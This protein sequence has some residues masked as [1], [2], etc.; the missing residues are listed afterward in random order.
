M[1]GRVLGIIL[2]AFVFIGCN[3]NEEVSGSITG[4]VKDEITGES[5]AGAEIAIAILSKSTQT[6]SDGTFSFTNIPVGTYNL[7]VAKEGYP[8]TKKVV[9]V[10]DGQSVETSITMS[11]TLPTVTPEEVTLNYNRLSDE[12]EIENPGDATLAI[13]ITSSQSWLSVDQVSLQLAPS[14]KKDLTI[15]ADITG[16]EY[17]DYE[18]EVTLSFDGYS[19][20]V[21]VTVY[22]VEQA[23]IIWRNWYLS[24]PIDN[25]DGKATSI[26]YEDIVNDNL[27]NEEREYFDYDETTGSYV[28]WTKFTGY[29]TS[30]EYGLNEGSYCRTELREFWQGNQ[31]V[32][33]NWYFNVGET[34][35]MESTLNVDFVEGSRG[36]TFVGQIH[37]KKSTI[38]GVDNGPA[39]VK[40]LWENGDIEVEYYV[41]PANPN[42]EWTSDDNDKSDRIT[43][44]NEKFTI[45]LKVEDGVLYWAL[46]CAAKGIDQDYVMLYDYAS[47]GYHY[48]NYFKTGN[49]FQWNVDYDK[50]A[51]VRLY[52]VLTHHE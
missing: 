47:N 5:I 14:E 44:D 20:A 21:P 50:E 15:T 2:I 4:V 32:N 30:G 1:L 52:K 45:K 49:Y 43:V 28:M 34:H 46:E 29:T 22:H 19:I 16:L 24:V 23:D 8:E 48:D 9:S 40:V 18:E 51:Q 10:L 26:Y 25:G 11:K 17:G 35:I 27:T 6:Q 33:D 39:T 36:R 42:G 41:A 37:G 3:K 38:A 13:T 7:T 31:T 12:V